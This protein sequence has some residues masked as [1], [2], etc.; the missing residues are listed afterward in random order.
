MRV[1]KVD[2][3]ES[4]DVGFAVCQAPSAPERIE[5]FFQVDLY[6]TSTLRFDDNDLASRR[7]REVRSEVFLMRDMVVGHR[8]FALR[9]AECLLEHPVAVGRRQVELPPTCTLMYHPS[10]LVENQEGLLTISIAVA[11]G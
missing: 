9:L 5:T 6:G 11:A 2:K 10:E 7:K 4:N 8:H 1:R 3:N